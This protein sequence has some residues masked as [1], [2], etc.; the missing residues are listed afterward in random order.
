MACSTASADLAC[1]IDVFIGLER[2]RYNHMKG[3]HPVDK[4]CVVLF[5]IFPGSES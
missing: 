2:D 5:K 3:K 4:N 1:V